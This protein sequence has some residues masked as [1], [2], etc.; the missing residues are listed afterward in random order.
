MT[1]ED[2]LLRRTKF[3]LTLPPESRASVVA[4]SSGSAEASLHGVYIVE[5]S[6]Y[7]C[8]RVGTHVQIHRP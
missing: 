2:F 3:Q 8:I 7:G 4:G 1:A 6:T 5:L